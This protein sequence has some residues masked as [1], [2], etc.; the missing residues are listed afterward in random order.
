MII[1]LLLCLQAKQYTLA[2]DKVKTKKRACLLEQAR[3][4]FKHKITRCLLL[5][6]CYAPTRS[7]LIVRLE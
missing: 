4:L 7:L 6:S 1:K 3:F 2:Y 5:Y